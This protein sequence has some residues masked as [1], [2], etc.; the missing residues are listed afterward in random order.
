MLAAV[1]D[2]GTPRRGIVH[3]VVAAAALLGALAATDDWLT[4]DRTLGNERNAVFGGYQRAAE[5]DAAGVILLGSSTTADWLPTTYLAAIFGVGRADVLRAHINGCHQTCTLAE[6]RHL[7]SRGRHFDVA[8]FG[9]NQ[10]QMCEYAHSKRVLQHRMMMPTADLPLL[11]GLYARSQA[12][13]NYMGRFIGGF[14][15]GAYAE[16]ATLQQLWAAAA[17][18]EAHDTKRARWARPDAPRSRPPPTLCGYTEPEVRY[19]T[20]AQEALL[21]SMSELADRVFVLLL[22]EV[23]LSDPSPEAAAA[24]QRHRDNFRRMADARPSVVL[25]DLTIEGPRDPEDFTDGFHLDKHVK[26]KQRRRLTEA[27]RQGGHIDERR[28]R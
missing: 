17:F 13:L 19:K 24:W 3:G 8:V 4:H 22:P 25:I 16:T 6:V 12:P 27:L 5:T 14:V 10:F 28:R 1:A 18:G 20:A 26:L 2:A 21:D 7:L 15:S 23:T 11:F 9:T